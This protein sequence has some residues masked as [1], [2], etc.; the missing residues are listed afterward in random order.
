MTPPRAE[1]Q[2]DTMAQIGDNRLSVLAGQVADLHQQVTTHIDA[3]AT[4]KQAAAMK[5]LEAGAALIEA[6]KLLPHGGWGPWLASAGIPERSAQ[7]YMR[8]SRADMETAMVALLG[9]AEADRVAARMEKIWPD[10]GCGT[11]FS[12]RDFRGGF[13]SVA[14]R[15]DSAPYAFLAGTVLAP[16]DATGVPATGHRFNCHRAMSAVGLAMFHSMEVGGIGIDTVFPFEGE[17]AANEHLR[18]F[19]SKMTEKGLAFVS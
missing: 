18:S 3:A 7:R 12:G 17:Q 15:P 13:I 8:L 11:L 5:A 1:R 19:Q 4:H 10:P 16:P 2:A 6:K 14:W 9:V